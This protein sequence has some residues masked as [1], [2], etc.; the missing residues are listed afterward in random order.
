MLRCCEGSRPLDCLVDL[1]VTCGTEVGFGGGD[2]E[3]KMVGQQGSEGDSGGR[4]KFKLC[5]GW[6][7]E[8]W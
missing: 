3:D 8:S 1:E 4:K 2:D 7:V 5:W 6:R